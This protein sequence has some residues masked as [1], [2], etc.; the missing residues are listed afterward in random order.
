MR[1]ITSM[2]AVGVVTVGASVAPMAE[3]QELLSLSGDVAGV[4]DP[5]VIKEGRDEHHV[6]G[7]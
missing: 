3:P 6:E 4:H 7:P 1:R 2:L 5:S